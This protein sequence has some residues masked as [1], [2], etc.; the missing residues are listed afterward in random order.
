MTVN[1][2]FAGDQPRRQYFSITT[3]GDGTFHRRYTKRVQKLA[4]VV[5]AECNGSVCFRGL[6]SWDGRRLDLSR[7][8]LCRVGRT[9]EF[10]NIYLSEESQTRY[11]A[12]CHPEQFNSISILFFITTAMEL[13][14]DVSES[15]VGIAGFPG[16][17][18][19]HRHR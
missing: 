19:G 9:H 14:T 10:K 5:A 13:S 1:V 8:P 3:N 6:R 17:G 11:R 16:K 15:A 2:E 12:Y 18:L 4:W 7:Q